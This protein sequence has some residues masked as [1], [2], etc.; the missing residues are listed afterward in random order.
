VASDAR[1]TL[2]RLRRCICSG[3]T[4]SADI[5]GG[6]WIGGAANPS[7][8]ACWR[9]RPN[10]RNPACTR[11]GTSERAIVGVVAREMRA[12]SGITKKGGRCWRRASSSRNKKR[13][14]RI[15]KPRPSRFLAPLTERYAVSKSSGVYRT[16]SSRAHSSATHA[17]R[18]R[19]WSRWSR[20]SCSARRWRTS[21]AA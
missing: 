16:S 20:V 4:C 10:R 5:G 6:L 14:R 13:L 15:A 9:P 11:P 2:R 17:V 3:L 18:P 12:M 1:Q 21:L 7:C 8:R 19:D